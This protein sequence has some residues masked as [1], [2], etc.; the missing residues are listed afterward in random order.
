MSL[1]GPRIQYGDDGLDRSDLASEPHEQF[2]RWFSEA[3]AA[4]VSE[5][6]AFV[7][8]TVDQNGG[9][10]ARVVL[11][12]GVDE[13]GIVFFTNYSSTK[14]REMATAIFVAATF[15]WLPMH[16][17]VRVRGTVVKA[18]PQESDAYFA[19][20]PIESQRGA[21][22]SPQSEVIADRQALEALID[23]VR[24]RFGEAPPP[25]PPHWGG[26]RVTPQEWEF[27]QGRSNRLH[28][29]FRYLRRDDAWLIDRL[30][31]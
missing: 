15:V 10:N 29:R 27:W 12:R 8:S 26:W 2:A 20:R 6:N 31:P 30:A 18:S 16:R 5:P 3:Q 1:F 4:G 19:T 23:A 28:D 21:W 22:A 14:S 25:R 9:A 13:R 11:A 7:L 17:Q 24:A